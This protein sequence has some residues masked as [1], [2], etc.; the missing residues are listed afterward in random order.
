VVTDGKGGSAEASMVF[1]V[2]CCGGGF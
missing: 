1:K 2:L